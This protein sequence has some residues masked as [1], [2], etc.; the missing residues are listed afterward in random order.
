MFSKHAFENP[1]KLFLL[2]SSSGTT[3]SFD[4]CSKYKILKE[5]KKEIPKVSLVAISNL[6]KS[7]YFS[8]RMQQARSDSH[9]QK[10]FHFS[11]ESLIFCRLA[12]S[13]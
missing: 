9:Y 11:T 2:P 6:T 5:K 4:I 13:N 10:V 8:E 12:H 1:L 7:V 3:F